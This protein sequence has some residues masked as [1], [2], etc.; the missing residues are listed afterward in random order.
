[1]KNINS[2]LIAILTLAVIYLFFDKFSSQGNE[3]V[4]TEEVDAAVEEEKDVK[5][6]YINIDSLDNQYKYIKDQYE[7]LE[8]ENSKVQS[9]IQ[10]KMKQ[11]EN[12]QAELQQQLPGM[13]QSQFE[14]AQKELE[15]MQY[16]FQNYQNQQ[17]Q[18]LQDIQMATQEKIKSQLDSFLTPYKEKYDFIFS[19]AQG[20][21]LMHANEAHEITQEVISEMNAAYDKEMAAEEAE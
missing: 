15:K 7:I 5:F 10:N 21:E 19:Y 13:T 8:K 20:T 9:R 14:A 4:T 1:M 3:D 12:R 18:I 11:A 16:D 2:I 17:A 6:A